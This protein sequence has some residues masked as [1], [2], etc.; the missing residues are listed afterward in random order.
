MLKGPGFQPLLNVPDSGSF[1]TLPCKLTSHHRH[2]CSPEGHYVTIPHTVPVA[3][4][5]IIAI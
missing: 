2:H 3:M 5:W 4:I 1:T